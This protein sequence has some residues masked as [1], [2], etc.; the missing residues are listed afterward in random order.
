MYI[1][2]NLF[3]E[4][5]RGRERKGGKSIQNMTNRT[6]LLYELLFLNASRLTK[7]R[8]QMCAVQTHWHN[9]TVIEAK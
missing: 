5:E 6:K 9:V 1:N 2:T 3:P 4:T 8:D 7:S